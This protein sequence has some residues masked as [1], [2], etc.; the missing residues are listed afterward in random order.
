[1]RYINPRLILILKDK[2]PGP[3]GLHPMLLRMC[4]VATADP[5]ALIFQRSFETGLVPSDWRVADIVPIF[6]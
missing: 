2:A 4:A 5:L 6:K 1:M 3:N